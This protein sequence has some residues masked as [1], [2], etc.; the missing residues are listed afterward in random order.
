MLSFKEY[1]QIT[2]ALETMEAPIRHNDQVLV[3]RDYVLKLLR[4]FQVET[5]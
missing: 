1:E 5:E 2:A 3:P 4:T